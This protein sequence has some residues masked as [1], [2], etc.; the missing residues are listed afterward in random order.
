MSFLYS[1]VIPQFTFR[2]E[3]RV[4]WS[5]EDVYALV[6]SIFFEGREGPR[7]PTGNVN[8]LGF[9]MPRCTVEQPQKLSM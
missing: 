4:P 3:D 6:K 9:S 7:N 5:A 8:T 2:L 1:T